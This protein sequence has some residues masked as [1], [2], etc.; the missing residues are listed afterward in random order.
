MVVHVLTN[1]TRLDTCY[2]IMFMAFLICSCLSLDGLMNV[3]LYVYVARCG[4]LLMGFVVV[5]GLECSVGV[6]VSVRAVRAVGF[7]YGNAS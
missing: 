7:V 2:K 5:T 1:Y 3:A 4:E 6:L